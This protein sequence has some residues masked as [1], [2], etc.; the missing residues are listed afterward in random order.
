METP[1]EISETARRMT[2][3]ILPDVGIQKETRN[4]IITG[5]VCELQTEIRKNPIFGNATS[6]S[7]NFMKV[8]G[9][10]DINV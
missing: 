6:K 10:V 2:M 9:V 5:L 7:A 8:C 1:P 4:F 3:K